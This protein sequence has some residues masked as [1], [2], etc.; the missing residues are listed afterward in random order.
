M[1]ISDLSS[2][3]CS[4]DL[5]PH[6]IALAMIIASEPL[7]AIAAA[8]Y[9]LVNQCVARADLS[10]A[11]SEWENKVLAFSPLLSQAGKQAALDGLEHSLPTALTRK[12]KIRCESWRRRVCRYVDIT[13]V[14]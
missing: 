5:L 6:H 2:D 9:G 8:R 14:H 1:R 12:Y 4:S 10:H 13:D 7:D 11:L 3:V